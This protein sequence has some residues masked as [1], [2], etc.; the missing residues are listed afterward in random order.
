MSAPGHAHKR[1]L[2]VD[3][4]DSMR[5][6]LRAILRQ[7]QYDVVGELADGRDF[8]ATVKRLAPDIVCL[9]QNLPSEDGLSLLRALHNA[10]PAIAVLMVTG[11]NN[12]ALRKDAL[13]AGVAGFLKKPFSQAQIVEELKNVSKVQ[14]ARQSVAPHPTPALS[15]KRV[16]VADDSLTMRGLLRKILEN[17]GM[18]VVGEAPEGALAAELVAQHAPDMVCLDVEMPGTDGIEALRRIHAAN[19]ATHVIMVTSAA[20]AH[21]VRE[22]ILLGAKG[23][24]LKPLQPEQIAKAV[25]KLFASS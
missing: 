16:I 1:V 10:N 19:P 9:D 13:D 23:Y 15:G 17:L 21:I 4:N 25:G 12:P 6:I 22:A 24:I 8:L 2:V 5:A 11:S 3:D 14:Q 20:D 7:E 18:Q